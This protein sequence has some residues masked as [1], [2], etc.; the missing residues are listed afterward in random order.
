MTLALGVGINGGLLFV[1]ERASYGYGHA[2]GHD[3]ADCLGTTLLQVDADE[4][5]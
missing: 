2:H 3:L 5:N 1:F 4:H